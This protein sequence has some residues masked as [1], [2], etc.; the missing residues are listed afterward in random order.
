MII[1]SVPTDGKSIECEVLDIFTGSSGRKV[2]TVR[3]LR[4][5]PF[6]S[7]THGGWCA[8]N[9]CT[10]PAGLLSRVAIRCTHE[11]AELSSSG[12]FSFNGEPQDNIEDR[13]YCLD[14]D[15]YLEAV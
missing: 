12:G 2:A 11:H 4:G 15:T 10:I 1:A 5:M 7:Y 8:S 6:Q 14:C 9:S 3:A 13:V